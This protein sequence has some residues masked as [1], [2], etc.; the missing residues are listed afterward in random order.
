MLEMGLD[1]GGYDLFDLEFFIFIRCLIIVVNKDEIF[2]KGLFFF[3]VTRFVDRV[4][5]CDFDK[6]IGEIVDV[7]KF[8]YVVVIGI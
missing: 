8:D 3:D 2:D 6:F 7:I 4:I 1:E 5:C